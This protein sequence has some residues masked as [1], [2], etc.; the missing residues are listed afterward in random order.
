MYK[1]ITCQS[2]DFLIFL[3]CPKNMCTCYGVKSAFQKKKMKRKLIFRVQDNTE[4]NIQRFKTINHK[5]S[6]I[7]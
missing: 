1:A 5:E 3:E 4:E 6:K 2:M 7:L